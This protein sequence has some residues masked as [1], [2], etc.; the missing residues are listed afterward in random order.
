MSGKAE[1]IIELVAEQ[2]FISTTELLDKSIRTKGHSAARTLAIKLLSEDGDQAYVA[3]E[4]GISI[5]NVSRGIE[6]FEDLQLLDSD[7]KKMYKAIK[8]EL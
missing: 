3:E 8:N 2:T 1:R 6:R 5:S 7:F 4:M